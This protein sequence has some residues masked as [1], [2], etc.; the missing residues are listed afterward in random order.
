M[1]IEINEQKSYLNSEIILK[2]LIT[3]DDK[4]NTLIMCKSSE[5]NLVT[6]DYEVYEAIGSIKPY[7]NFK[8]NKLTKLLEVIELV[9][10]PNK[11]KNK[12]ILK[13]KRVEELR[14]LALS[15]GD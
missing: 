9:P 11:D 1:K 3:E 7:D 5:I 4:I 6:S 8:L 15:K 12:D 14:K 10:H 2:Y 13:E